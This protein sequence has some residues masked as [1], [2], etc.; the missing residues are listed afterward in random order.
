MARLLWRKMVPDALSVIV[1]D[2]SAAFI[3]SGYETTSEPLSVHADDLNWLEQDMLTGVLRLLPIH[4]MCWLSSFVQNKPA[5]AWKPFHPNLTQTAAAQL[6]AWETHAAVKLPLCLGVRS[7]TDLEHI[8]AGLYLTLTRPMELVKLRCA[9]HGYQAQI[10]L[11][12]QGEAAAQH[13]AAAAEA[14]YRQQA[15]RDGRAVANPIVQKAYKRCKP[16]H[17]I[18]TFVQELCCYYPRLSVNALGDRPS[19]ARDSPE[20]KSSMRSICKR[21]IRLVHPDKAAEGTSPLQEA[22]G[23]EMNAVLL[24][25]KH[26]YAE[27]LVSCQVRQDANL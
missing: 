12:K 18:H 19:S 16:G 11:E 6:H 22:Y 13:A 5:Q 23:L 14:E 24:D 26:V 10:Q 25:W 3:G 27:E 9:L 7:V 20:W 2:A 15:V 1:L 4:I 17:D 8:D 21:A